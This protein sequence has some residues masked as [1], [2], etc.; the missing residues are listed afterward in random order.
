MNRLPSLSRFLLR[1]AAVAAGSLALAAGLAACGSDSSSATATTKDSSALE[2][3][4]IRYQQ[5]TGWVTPLELAEQLGYLRGLTLKSIGDSQ[6]GPQD[7]QFVATDQIDVGLTFNGA[8]VKAVQSGARVKAVI[9]S[10]GVD[11][12]YYAGY[13]VRADSP[14][15]SAR[16]LI[17]K[18]VGL[19]SLGA[20]QEAVLDEW[21][22]RGGLDKDEVAKVERVALPPGFT[23]QVVR[24]G[25]VDLVVLRG[26]VQ[27]DALSRGGIRELFSDYD[28]YGDFTAG[29][30]VMNPRFIAE[31]PNTT[32]HLVAGVAKAIDWVQTHPRKDVIALAIAVARQHDRPNDVATLKYWKS[33]GIAQRGGVV[34]FEDVDRWRRWLEDTGAIPKGSVDS[35]DVFTNEF[36]P[37]AS[38]AKG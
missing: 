32:R 17:G 6:G 30:L 11:K 19:N 1:A 10:Y 23:D 21:L 7:I 5:I 36:N 31:H 24:K 27:A 25:L 16:D 29:T 35:K 4:T 28:L 33:L 34:A 18:K 9:G 3:T 2:A 13:Y 26:I 8:L 37:Y 12:D 20:Q 38:G 14:I 22:R 15:R